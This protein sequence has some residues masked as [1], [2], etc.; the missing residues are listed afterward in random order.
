M[1]REV[2]LA[3]IWAY[4]MEPPTVEIFRAAFVMNVR[5]PE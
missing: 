1:F 3:N 2:C 4:R 5:L